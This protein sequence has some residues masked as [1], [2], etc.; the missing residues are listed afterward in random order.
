MGR[1][2]G[3]SM[4]TRPPIRVR[5]LRTF[6]STHKALALGLLALVVVSALT[7]IALGWK[8][9]VALLQPPTATGEAATLERW[10]PLHRLAAIA[11][12]ALAAEIGR[13]DPARLVPERLDVRPDRGIVKVLF[14]GA[15]EV[16]MDGATGEVLSVA[17]RHADW[18]ETLHDGSIISDGFKLLAMN[19]LGLG[20]LALSATGVWVWYGPRRIRKERRAEREARERQEA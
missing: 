16:Q 4:T 3:D 20:L 5:V 6:R 1:D 12:T 9:N 18:I 15:W 17:R 7:G 19:A 8:K 11:G 2:D 10:A 13:D 14:P